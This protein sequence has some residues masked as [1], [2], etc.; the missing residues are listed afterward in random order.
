MKTWQ[1]ASSENRKCV[2]CKKKTGH[3]KVYDQSD[4]TV[5]IP[6]C[7]EHYGEVDVKA[8]CKVTISAITETLKAQAKEEA[9]A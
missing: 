1:R 2:V 8:I 4:I 9:T 7:E 6:A 3:Y 5:T